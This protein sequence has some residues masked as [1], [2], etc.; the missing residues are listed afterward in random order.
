MCFT[1]VSVSVTIEAK[2]GARTSRHRCHPKRR[3]P[4]EA[5]ALAGLTI[6][7]FDPAGSDRS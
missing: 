6:A 3:Q 1:S 2:P 7:L 4:L 5:W